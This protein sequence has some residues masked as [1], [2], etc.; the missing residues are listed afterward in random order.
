MQ[1]H[2]SPTEAAEYFTAMAKHV[3]AADSACDEAH[4][5]ITSIIETFAWESFSPDQRS[6]I[7][8]WHQGV[9]AARIALR[10]PSL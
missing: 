6:S 1:H 3:E 4:A 2:A 10:L 5:F 9:Q 7:K 8:E